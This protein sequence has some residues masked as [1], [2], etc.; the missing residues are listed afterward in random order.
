MN[1]IAFKYFRFYILKLKTVY[2]EVK[3]VLV[4]AYTH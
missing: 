1:I 4:G 2:A 3:N